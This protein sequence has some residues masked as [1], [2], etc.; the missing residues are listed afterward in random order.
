MVT[1]RCVS[2]SS[3]TSCDVSGFSCVSGPSGT[4]WLC[5]VLPGNEG[6]DDEEGSEIDTIKLQLKV[7]CSRNPRATKDSADPRELYLNHMG[8]YYTPGSTSTTWVSTTPP[9]CTCTTLVDL[10]CTTVSNSLPGT[11]LHRSGSYLH[12]HS[13]VVPT[14]VSTSVLFHLYHSTLV[15]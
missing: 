6:E 2:G 5:F 14:W 1:S 12:Y 8:Q 11:V 3:A 9:G 4:S 10:T 7:K 15:P 13:T